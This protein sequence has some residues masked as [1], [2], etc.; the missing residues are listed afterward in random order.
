MDAVRVSAL[1]ERLTG[2][3]WLEAVGGF[4]GSLRRSVERRGAGGLL[5][6]GTEAY[7]PWHLAAHLEDE[8]AWSAVP[9][10]APT[11]LRHHPPAGAPAHLAH[12]LRRLA[13]AGRGATVLVV[14]PGAAGAP[15]LERVHD[16]RRQGA[17][18]LALDGAA[19]AEPGDLGGL[20][21]ERLAVGTAAEEPFDLAQHLVSTAAGQLPARRSPLDRLAAL[22]ARLT[23]A[24]AISRW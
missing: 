16:A 1:R 13:A 4:A 19:P 12:D 10:L 22:A 7:E 11:L 24:P 6:V 3:G 18:V 14:A 15:L 8:A 23:S 9:R 21:H 20:A 5:L 2:T 17:T